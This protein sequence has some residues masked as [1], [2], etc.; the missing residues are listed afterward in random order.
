MARSTRAEQSGCGA[1]V[2]VPVCSDALFMVAM[3]VVKEAGLVEET[4]E[5][6]AWIIA[7]TSGKYFFKL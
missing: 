2:A 1:W 6:T 5:D 7:T 3:V 4:R